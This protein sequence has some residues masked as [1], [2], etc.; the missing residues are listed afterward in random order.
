MA[1]R[2]GNSI[3]LNGDGW[4]FKIDPEGIGDFQEPDGSIESWERSVKFFDS[5]FDASDWD[6]IKV[7]ANW[8]TEGYSYNGTAW[9]RTTFTYEPDGWN[10]VVRINFDGIDYYGDVW[11]N[12]YYLGSHE[13]FFNRFAFDASRWIRSGEN[14]LVVK[15]DAPDTP[16]SNRIMIKGALKGQS[17]DCNDPDADPGGICNDVSLLLSRDVYIDGMKVTP[18]VDLEKTTARVHCRTCICNTT[19]SV[20]TVDLKYVISPDNF[21]GKT[22]AVTVDH[23]VV[24]GFSEIEAWIEVE[25]PRLWWPWDMGDQNLYTIS[26]AASDQSRALDEMSDRIGLRHIQKV[27]SGWESYINGK[28]IFGRGPNYLSEQYQSNMTREKYA[29]HVRLMREANMN[30]VRV[31][32]VVEKEEFYDECD[33]Q[34]VL[35]LQ[36]FPMAGRMSNTGDLVRRA[37]LQGRDMVNQL[38]NHPSIIIWCWGAQPGIKNFEKLGSALAQVSSQEGPF[39]FIQQGSSVWQWRRAKE[40]YDWPIDYHLLPG[41]FH[42]DDRFGPFLLHEPEE[43]A[44]GDTVEA[45]KIKHKELLEF[46]GEYGPPEALPEMDSLKKIIPEKDRWPVNWDVYEHHCLHGSILRRYVGEQ[47]SLE[48]LIEKSQEYQ[49]FHLK[50]HT[51][52]YRRHKFAPCNGALFFQFS[53]CWPAVT[54]AVVDYYGKKKKAYYALQK[55]FAPLHVMV[56][57]PAI[58]GEPAG[59]NFAR[60]ILVVNDFLRAFPSLVVN[61]KIVALGGATLA[62]GSVECSIPEN[63]LNEVG[64]VSWKIPAESGEPYKIEAELLEGSEVMASNQYELRIRST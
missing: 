60:K 35:V 49:A 64:E 28:R 36:D 48:A 3:S 51:E 27:K 45:L 47:E 5:E 44:S 37:V 9:Y 23:S 53:D 57:W 17:W 33:E 11:L 40:R 21:S 20:K 2:R 32:I 42:S 58:D 6:H 8:Q 29:T 4:Q 14:L 16:G 15:V 1:R 24:P 26:V 50:Y 22:S 56:D 39:R 38:Y 25:D 12:G 62:N 41:W 54:A 18:Y 13:G 46:V 63:S 43:D 7:P 55:A 19:G 52:F 10:N 61:W 31:Y 30:M 59:R 34:G